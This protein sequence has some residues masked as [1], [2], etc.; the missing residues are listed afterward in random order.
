MRALLTMSDGIEEEQ[1][2]E[3]SAV[4]RLTGVSTPNIRVWEKRHQVV[5]PKRTESRRRLYTSE[6]IRRLTLLKALVDRGDSIGTI[7]SLKTIQL[8]Q[9]LAAQDGTGSTRE[10]GARSCRIV[11]IG[12]TLQEQ[13]ARESFVPGTD[14]VA[15]FENFA[16]AQESSPAVV[17]VV[18]IECATLFEDTIQLVQKLIQRMQA[19]RA[20]IVYRFTQQSTVALIEKGIR[21]ITPLRAPV[22]AQELQVVLQADVGVATRASAPAPASNTDGTIPPRQFTDKQLAKASQASTT[23]E[24][25][26]PQHLG[27]L[28]TSLT[29]FEKYSAECESRSPKDE[30]LHQFLHQTTAQ[31]RSTMEHALKEVIEAEGITL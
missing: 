7:A 6:D 25:E 11:V 3:I 30:A 8:E 10:T 17:D 23:I 4:S 27:S 18:L 28:L 19:V 12:E 24:C 29:A 13:F 14:L 22:N 16:E 21:G 15:S 5:D 2:Y 20:V 1:V 31:A 26:C 9:R